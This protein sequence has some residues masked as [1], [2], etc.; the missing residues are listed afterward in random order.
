MRKPTSKPGD[1]VARAPLTIAGPNGRIVRS[2]ALIDRGIDPLDYFTPDENVLRIALGDMRFVGLFDRSGELLKL[3]FVP[4]YPSE[5]YRPV[6]DCLTYFGILVSSAA[7][8]DKAVYQLRAWDCRYKRMEWQQ[9][10]DALKKVPV[11]GLSLYQRAVIE[12]VL[13]LDAAYNANRP[14][15]PPSAMR[16]IVGSATGGRLEL[17]GLALT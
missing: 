14:N 1:A 8:Q 12:R 2:F 10:V 6:R 5:D 15:L 9:G 17:K 16:D 11:E 7:E 4:E 3:F 13:A